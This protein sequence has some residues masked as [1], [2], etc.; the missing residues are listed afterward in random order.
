MGW[1]SSFTFSYGFLFYS[2]CTPPLFDLR[3]VLFS[4]SREAHAFFLKLFFFQT[5]A[6]GPL[7]VHISHATLAGFRFFLFSRFDFSLIFSFIDP[8]WADILSHLFE[9]R[10]CLLAGMATVHYLPMRL[11]TYDG[12]GK[13]QLNTNLTPPY[14]TN[15]PFYVLYWRTIARRVGR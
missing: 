3:K 8:A 9:E 1:R 14:P 13:F 10:D 5:S 6:T 11:S 4:P 7:C 2:P 15:V 12:Y